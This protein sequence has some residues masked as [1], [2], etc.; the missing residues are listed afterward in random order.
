ML[1]IYNLDNI[2]GPAPAKRAFTLIELLVVISVIALLIGLLLPALKKAKESARR[3]VCLSNHHQINN[4][5]AVYASEQNG[6]YP[7]SHGGMNAGATYYATSPWARDSGAAFARFGFWGGNKGWTAMGLLFMAEILVDP[8]LMY[9]PSQRF[10][11]FTYPQGW[12][13]APWGGYHV[14]GYMYRL[15]GQLSSG[16]TPKDISQLH[17]YRIS[18]MNDPIALTS[19]I[20]LPGSASQGPYPED[21]LWAHLDPSVLNVSFSDGHCETVADDRLFDY[22]Q[23]ALPLYGNADRFS[24]MFWEYLDG[25]PQR[26]SASYYLPED[27]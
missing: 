24:M 9:C 18:D 14:M 6:R 22:S 1:Q 21:T 20:F 19:D 26:L 25:K 17:N 11:N 27:F 10:P 13:H 7:P 3:A 12:F 4:A 23:V 2:T 5:L 16:I 8:T 15:F